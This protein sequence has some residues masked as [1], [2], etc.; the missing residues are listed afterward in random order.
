M[1]VLISASQDGEDGKQWILDLRALAAFAE[2][3]DSGP[4][5][6]IVAHSHL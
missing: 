2:D 6:H 1:G 5:T 3:F 4:S